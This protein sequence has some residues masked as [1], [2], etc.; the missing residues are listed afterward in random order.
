MC[1]AMEQRFDCFESNE[2]YFL[3]TLS[4]PRFKFPFFRNK[5]TKEFAR[6]LLI[7]KV[8][9]KLDTNEETNSLEFN[10]TSDD[11][12]NQKSF[13]T[14]MQKVINKNQK[15]N[16]GNTKGKGDTLKDDIIEI[17]DTYCNLPQTAT[18][19][20]FSFWKQKKETGNKIW[21]ALSELASFYL[22]PPPSSTECERL[23]STAGDILTPSRSCLEPAIAEKLLFLRENFPKIHFKY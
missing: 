7:Q 21:V 18:N 14:A 19:V 23:F 2:D 4:N 1:L 20:C 13:A 16:I 9:E 5:D 6:N 15:K 11:S 8:C 3:A 22:T 17:I 12:G 10:S